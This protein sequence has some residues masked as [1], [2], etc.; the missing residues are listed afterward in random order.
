VRADRSVLCDSMKLPCPFS[1]CAPSRYPAYHS[2]LL[3]CSLHLPLPPFTPPLWPQACSSGMCLCFCLCTRDCL[4]LSVHA[5]VWLL[6]VL[7]L[8]RRDLH[9]VPP[10][11]ADLYPLLDGG[12]S[13]EHGARDTAG[14]RWVGGQIRTVLS[15]WRLGAS[16]A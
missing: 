11:P 4:A 1:A 15:P 10:R 5:C 6:S 16:A 2:S 8:C 3:W 12:C 13:R 7:C 9:F 14:G